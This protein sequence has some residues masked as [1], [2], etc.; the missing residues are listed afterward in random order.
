M[1]TNSRYTVHS[2]DFYPRLTAG[3]TW[4]APERSVCAT[5]ASKRDAF[6]SQLRYDLQLNASAAQVVDTATQLASLQLGLDLAFPASTGGYPAA[7]QRASEFIIR[8]AVTKTCTE[9]VCWTVWVL[10]VINFFTSGSTSYVRSL[11]FLKAVDAWVLTLLT[12]QRPQTSD[13]G[14]LTSA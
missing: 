12:L 1:W 6:H 10:G 11:L 13:L 5:M 4:A 3:L 7:C 8:Q 14:L 2:C 9:E